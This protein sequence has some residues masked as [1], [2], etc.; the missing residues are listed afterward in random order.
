MVKR[1]EGGKKEGQ[2]RVRGR[3]YLGTRRDEGRQSKL[4][5]SQRRE[6]DGK[7]KPGDA[8]WRGERRDEERGLKELRVGWSRDEEVREEEVRVQAKGYLE[9]P[10]DLAWQLRFLNVPPSPI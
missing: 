7:R 2:L 3:V 6:A 9:A 5:A 4:R 10:H 1:G 8:R